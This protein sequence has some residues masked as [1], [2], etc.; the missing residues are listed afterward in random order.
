MRILFCS[1]THLSKEL[2]AS[3]VLIE[4]AEEMEQ[5]GWQCTLIS[6]SDIA[7]GLN[8]NE[9]YCAQL[10]R[11][12]IKYADKYDVVEYDHGHLPYPR[13]DFPAGPLFV[14]RSVLLGHHFKKISIPRDKS[15]KGRVRSLMFERNEAAQ[16]RRRTE[17]AMAT[18]READLVNVANADD[19]AELIKCGVSVEKIVVIPYGMSRARLIEFD[20]VSD[21]TPREPVVVFVGTFDNRKGATDF[22]RIVQEISRAVPNVGFRL[23]GTY[24]DRAGVMNHFPR[25]LRS[26]I[27]VVPRF[28]ADELPGLLSGG[29]VGIFP[30]YVEGFGLGVLEMLAASIPVIAYDCPGPPEMLPAD[31][32]VRPGDWSAMSAKVIDLLRDEKGLAATRRWARQRSQQFRWQS[33]AQTTSEHY[34]KHWNAKTAAAQ[35]EVRA[36]CEI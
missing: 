30:S 13:S 35:A 8:G 15:I 6:P 11:Y 25:K 16:R 29:S 21:A 19:Q 7:S 34:F 33:I 20:A 28:D 1:R 26:R 32:L 14:A 24:R 18:V 23:L 17:R 12:L 9:D 36:G 27:E 2:G 5:L 10:R 22:P 3:K 31:Y 4:L